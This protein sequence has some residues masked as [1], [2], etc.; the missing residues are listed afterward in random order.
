MPILQILDSKFDE[1]DKKKRR[2]ESVRFHRAGRGCGHTAWFIV[3]VER[4]GLK[5][6]GVRQCV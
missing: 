2:Y 3:V 6:G 5:S 4:K 1:R